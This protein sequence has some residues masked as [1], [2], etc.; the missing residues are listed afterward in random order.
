M[1]ESEH[2]PVSTFGY[3]PPQDQGPPPDMGQGLALGQQPMMPPP[4][5]LGQAL[6]QQDQ[7][8]QD[9]GALDPLAALQDA[10]HAVTGALFA[11]QDPEDNASAVNALATLTK[12]QARMMKGAN[13][14][15]PR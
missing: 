4:Q 7:D 6:A 13:A 9:E 11:I 14:A 8:V 5:Q 3:G 10:I 1:G 12:I 2:N 15:P